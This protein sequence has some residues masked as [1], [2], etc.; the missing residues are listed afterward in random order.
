MYY[1]NY[2]CPYQCKAIWSWCLFKETTCEHSCTSNHSYSNGF[3]VT[4]HLEYFLHVDFFISSSESVEMKMNLC[5][6]MHCIPRYVCDKITHCQNGGRW[7]N[8]TGDLWMVGQTP[9]AKKQHN[10]PEGAKY[11][12]L[13]KGVYNA[14]KKGSEHSRS[15][16]GYQV[17]LHWIGA[18]T[19]GIEECA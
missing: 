6:I 1:F 14:Q 7:K 11:F 17:F 16:L 5:T 12:S 9:C 3:L 10:S 8:Q 18:Y 2:S 13:L 15:T 19:G 4:F